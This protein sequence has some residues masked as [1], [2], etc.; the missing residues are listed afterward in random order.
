MIRILILCT[1][2]SCRS[3]MAEA[4]LR[5]FDPALEVYSAGI[6]PADSV[7]SLAIA[8]MKES[9]ID[10]SAHT[11]KNVDL[12]L[13]EP[14]DYVIT[15]CSDA[16]EHC[17]YFTGTVRHRVHI[18]FDDPAAATGSP[19]DILRTFRDIRDQIRSALHRFYEDNITGSRT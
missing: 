15:V 19:D 6:H 7:H 13:A 3:Q 9:G 4:F 12:F 1:G 5:S 14:F 16:N 11:S 10:L 18:G 17:P 8:V 2:N